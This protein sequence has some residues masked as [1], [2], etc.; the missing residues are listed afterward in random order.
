VRHLGEEDGLDRVCDARRCQARM[1]LANPQQQRV[2]HVRQKHLGQ[3][4]WRY[5]EVPR[6]PACAAEQQEAVHVDQVRQVHAVPEV[7]AGEGVV[8]HGRM[9]ASGGGFYTDVGFMAFGY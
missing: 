7:G 5:G 2:R 6:L 3:G 4:E 1:G 8:H 9:G